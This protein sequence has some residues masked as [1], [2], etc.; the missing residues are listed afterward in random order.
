MK[1]I[2]LREDKCINCCA[3]AMVCALAH[4]GVPEMDKANIRP[5][6]VSGG[7]LYVCLQ[8]GKKFCVDTCL[9]KA[10]KSDPQTGAVIVDWEKCDG[11]AQCISCCPNKGGHVD[12]QRMK[13]ML[14]DLCEGDPSCVFAC[15]TGA[16][17]YLELNDYAQQTR[18]NVSERLKQALKNIRS[19]IYDE[20]TKPP[21][22]LAC[23]TGALNA[24]KDVICFNDQACIGCNKCLEICPLRDAAESGNIHQP[25]CAVCCGGKGINE[26]KKV[27]LI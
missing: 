9:K 1:R 20:N 27:V 24:S 2:I 3:C 16:L 17:S 23:L 13:V 22:V 15:N 14:C 10:L 8:C 4:Q 12:P 26:L 25:A 11:C 18:N 7:R 19:E 21:C 5:P 6:E